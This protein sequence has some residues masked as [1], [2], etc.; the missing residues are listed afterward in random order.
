M[1]ADHVAS[2]NI[3]PYDK[4]INICLISKQKN[5]SATIVLPKNGVVRIDVIIEVWSEESA[6]VI[7]YFCF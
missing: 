3:S 4:K 1:V 2:W 5:E 7:E 6:F